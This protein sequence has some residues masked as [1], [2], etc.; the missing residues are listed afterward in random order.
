MSLKT[1]L[2]FVKNLKKEV[3]MPKKISIFLFIPK[4]KNNEK[5]FVH[6]AFSQDTPHELKQ[7]SRGVIRWDQED[8]RGFLFDRAHTESANYVLQTDLPTPQETL[9]LETFIQRFL[10]TQNASL[11][12]KFFVFTNTTIALGATSDPPDPPSSVNLPSEV[13][14]AE[15]PTLIKT[16]M[17][18]GNEMHF[19]LSTALETHRNQKIS[20]ST[21][22]C[23]CA[24]ECSKK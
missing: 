21:P 15:V 8:W 6:T 22:A 14:E 20:I 7:K 11:A 4:E 24:E 23:Q 9:Q 16:M 2:M 3:A 17:A 1:P 5:A 13:E 18:I 19:R 12:E 10:N